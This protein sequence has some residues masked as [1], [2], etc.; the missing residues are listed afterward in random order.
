MVLTAEISPFDV[1]IG[2]GGDGAF[3]LEQSAGGRKKENTNT[4][5]ID[6]RDA[7]LYAVWG[8]E[9]RLDGLEI[10]WRRWP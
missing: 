6:R 10:Y 2:R 8:F 9:I 3:L 5:K 1:H 4:Y 7:V